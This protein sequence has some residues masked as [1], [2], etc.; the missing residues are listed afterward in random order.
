MTCLQVCMEELA[1]GACTGVTGATPA[2]I[3]TMT[4]C[5]YVVGIVCTY[6]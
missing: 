1:P 5:A 4:A 6:S 2:G 3:G